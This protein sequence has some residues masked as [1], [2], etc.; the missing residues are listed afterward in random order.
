[1]GGLAHV[2]V[3]YRGEAA[4]FIDLFDGKALPLERL[5]AVPEIKTILAERKPSAVATHPD[6]G[7]HR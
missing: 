5:L 4:L 2:P 1:M 6:P 7:T 3:L